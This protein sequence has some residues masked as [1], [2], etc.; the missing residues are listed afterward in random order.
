MRKLAENLPAAVYRAHP[1]FGLLRVPPDE[2]LLSPGESYYPTAWLELDDEREEELLTRWYAD[3]M[4]A[5][6]RLGDS[7]L[8][9]ELSDSRGR[10]GLVALSQCSVDEKNRFA[11]ECK[12][13][14]LVIEAALRTNPAWV[15]QLV[16]G[17][18]YM[19][20]LDGWEGMFLHVDEEAL[21]EGFSAPVAF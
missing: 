4:N 11:F 16:D 7:Q 12:A 14:P 20:A 5:I 19:S 3:L 1:M 15:F 10:E 8:H 6:A 18:V 9:I 2:P 21:V 17:T 13:T